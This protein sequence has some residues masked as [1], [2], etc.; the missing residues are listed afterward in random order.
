ME[1]LVFE[2]RAIVSLTIIYERTEAKAPK[3]GTAQMLAP[4]SGV[5]FDYYH[6]YRNYMQLRGRTDLR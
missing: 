3:A 4:A 5:G 1:K 2:Y 6:V